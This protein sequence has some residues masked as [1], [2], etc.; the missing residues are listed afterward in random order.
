MKKKT[1][2]LITAAQ[3]QALPTRWRKAHIEKQAGAPMC[4]ICDKRE[5]TNAVSLH[6]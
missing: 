3:D 2:G 4:R 6:N 5:E 1:K